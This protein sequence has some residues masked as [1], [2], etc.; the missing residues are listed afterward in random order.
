MKELSLILL[1]LVVFAF[2]YYVV[3]KV[4]DFLG[5]NKKGKNRKKRG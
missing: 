5:K 4:D 1:T 3:I 2:V